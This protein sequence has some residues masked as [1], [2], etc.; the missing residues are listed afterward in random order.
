MKECSCWLVMYVYVDPYVHFNLE[1]VLLP[2]KYDP[3]VSPNCSDVNF[4]LSGW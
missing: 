2:I 1:K 3:L 4:K